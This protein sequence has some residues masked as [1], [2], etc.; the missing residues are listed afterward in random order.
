M[1]D[2][3]GGPS[4]IRPND[5]ANPYPGLTNFSLITHSF[6]TPALNTGLGVLQTYLQELL[7]YYE[8]KKPIQPP[9]NRYGGVLGESSNSPQT[10]SHAGSV[11]AMHGASHPQQHPHHPPHHPH[12]HHPLQNPLL[13]ATRHYSST[14]GQEAVS[15]TDTERISVEVAAFK[16]EPVAS[17]NFTT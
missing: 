3:V 13:H 12:G 9:E 10:P 1:L 15:S 8:G 16:E 7:A 2:A 4:N 14:D 11:D 6:G 17:P 5:P